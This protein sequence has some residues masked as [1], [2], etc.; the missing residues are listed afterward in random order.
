[1]IAPRPVERVF[2]QG[3]RLDMGEAEIGDIG[4]QLVGQFAV[5]QIAAALG[6]VAA[7][8]AEMDLVDRDRGRAVVALPAL[9]HP[10]CVLPH[11]ARWRGD[12]RSGTGRGLRLL[13]MGIGL[14]RQQRAIGAEQLVFIEM[15]GDEAGHE[16]FPKPAGVPFAHRHAAAVPGVEIADHADPARV[17]AQPQAIPRHRHAHRMGAELLVA[18]VVVAFGDERRARQHRENR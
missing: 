3:H 18:G 9:G 1:M 7:P 10:G 6:E 5:A 17:G 2:G 16:D 14:Q 4:N 13:G 12:H 11:M 8:R 15:T